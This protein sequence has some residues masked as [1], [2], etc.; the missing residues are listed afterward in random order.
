[1]N[2][3]GS[4]KFDWDLHQWVRNWFHRYDGAKLRQLRAERG[5]GRP[6]R[7]DVPTARPLEPKLYHYVDLYGSQRKAAAALGMNLSTF[8]RRL[9]K[10]R[11]VATQ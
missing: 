9:A 1:M 7:P 5:V 8:Q 11:A 6:P 4:L 3:I 10:E 2:H